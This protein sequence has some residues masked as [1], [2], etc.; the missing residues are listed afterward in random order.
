MLSPGSVGPRLPIVHTAYCPSDAGRRLKR[1]Y[2]GARCPARVVCSSSEGRVPRPRSSILYQ[3]GA[4]LL[5]YCLG[6]THRL[7]I[8]LY[9]TA[10]KC[11]TALCDRQRMESAGSLKTGPLQNQIDK[12]QARCVAEHRC[13]LLLAKGYDG[14]SL[15]SSHP[16]HLFVLFAGAG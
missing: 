7:Q 15:L 8:G 4:R 1:A 9:I 11:D 14:P 5:K 16:R 12:L 3:E 6:R 13:L 10:A 2:S